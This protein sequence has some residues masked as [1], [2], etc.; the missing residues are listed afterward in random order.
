MSLSVP[1]C[2]LIALQLVLIILRTLRRAHCVAPLSFHPESRCLE[3]WWSHR[4][5][6]KAACWVHAYFFLLAFL[7]LHSF[8][9]HFLLFIIFKSVYSCSI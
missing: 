4:P 7:F 8:S 2:W 5:A 1:L 3:D 9:F 6:E